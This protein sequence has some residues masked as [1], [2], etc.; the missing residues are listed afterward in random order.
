M[1]CVYCQRSKAKYKLKNGKWCCCRHHNQCPASKEILSNSNKGKKHLWSEQGRI[2]FAELTK[3]RVPWNKGKNLS[4]EHLEHLSKSHLGQVAWNKGKI[5][6]YS[7]EVIESISEKVKEL[8]KNP[9][10]VK[11]IY[12]SLAHGMNKEESKINE[13]TE[14][15]DYKYTGDFSF[16]IGGKSPDFTNFE[17]KKVIE[18][19]GSWY[20]G[21]EY[22]RRIY[23]DFKSNKDHEIERIEHFKKYGFDCLI[24]WGDELKSKDLL[25]QKIKNF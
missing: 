12:K 11:K 19:F 21:E 9:E 8:W 7:K 6:V 17:K 10:F 20:H 22:R 4:Q 25:V 16:M 15:L 23:N 24:I 18:F 3:I 13:I 14:N 2:N 5:G 1:K